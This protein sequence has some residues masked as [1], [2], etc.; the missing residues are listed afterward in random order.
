MGKRPIMGASRGP[1]QLDWP[2]QRDYCGRTAVS[3]AAG[4]AAIDKLGTPRYYVAPVSRT[5]PP[6]VPVDPS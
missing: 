2:L 5:G 3:P 4:A 1:C 6:D